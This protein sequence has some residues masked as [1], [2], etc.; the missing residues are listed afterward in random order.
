MMDTLDSRWPAAGFR[1]RPASTAAERDEPYFRMAREGLLGCAMYA[2][3]RPSLEDWHA[4]IAPGL[5]LR[6]ED[7]AG[8]LLACGLFTPWRTRR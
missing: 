5:L 3:A 2:I 8:R 1:F 7:A 6:C 4:A